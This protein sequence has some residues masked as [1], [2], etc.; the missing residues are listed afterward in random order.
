MAPVSVLW[1]GDII[2]GLALSTCSSAHLQCVSSIPPLSHETWLPQLEEQ[3]PCAPWNPK[4]DTRRVLAK[5]LPSPA[6][7]SPGKES[8]LG[9]RPWTHVHFGPITAKRSGHWQGAITTTYKG[10]V[11]HERGQPLKGHQKM[12][13]TWWTGINKLW[14][15]RTLFSATRSLHLVEKPVQPESSISG[16]Q[17]LPLVHL[18]RRE[19]LNSGLLLPVAATGGSSPCHCDCVGKASLGFSLLLWGC[20]YNSINSIFLMYFPVLK[21]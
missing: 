9:G 16:N 19:Q 17:N 3:L 18:W 14:F 6:S 2:E 11:S 1:R 7:L 20:C 13:P 21:V 12:C 5:G 4:Q 8:F 10:A 15:Q